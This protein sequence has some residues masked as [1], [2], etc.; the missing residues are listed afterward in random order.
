MG[1]A[2][3]RYFPSNARFFAYCA[4]RKNAAGVGEQVGSIYVTTLPNI[5]EVCDRQL[6]G[7]KLGGDLLRSMG[8]S[9]SVVLLSVGLGVPRFSSR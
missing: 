8:R 5:V 6:A 7:V 9:A 2:E 3:S 1:F 4:P